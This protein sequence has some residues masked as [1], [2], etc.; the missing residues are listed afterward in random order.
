MPKIIYDGYCKL[1]GCYIIIDRDC[2]KCNIRETW[3]GKSAN[4]P[5]G[6][7]YFMPW[8]I[9]ETSKRTL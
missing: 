6:C 8:I 4:K 3:S 9:Y 5:Y 7:K 2:K 1:Y